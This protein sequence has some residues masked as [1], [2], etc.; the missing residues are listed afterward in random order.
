[1]EDEDVAKD[2][3]DSSVT[4]RERAIFECGISLGAIYHQF[5]GTPIFKANLELL[6]KA[7][8]SCI[9]SQ[10]FI[11]EVDV[12]ITP[13]RD[14]EGISPYVFC[15]ISGYNLRA[16]V[17]SKYGKYRVVGRLNYDE[18]LKYPLMY[19]EKVEEVD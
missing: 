11:E 12:K 19:I 7:I 8:K 16:K 10:P 2:R 18:E 14:V 9:E 1:M 15:E 4:D 13:P 3:F 5:V 17:V 6:E